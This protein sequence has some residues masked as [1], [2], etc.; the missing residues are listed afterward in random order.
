MFLPRKALPCSQAFSAASK[1]FRAVFDALR[2]FMEPPVP[3]KK[4]PIGY[5]IHEEHA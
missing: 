3:P 4:R 2:R 1:L 5:I